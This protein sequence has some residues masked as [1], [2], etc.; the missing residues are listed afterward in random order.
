MHTVLGSGPRIQ[1]Q[2]LLQLDHAALHYLDVLRHLAHEDGAFE[3][4]HDEVGCALGVALGTEP[5]RPL[6][7]MERFCHGHA[8]FAED[9]SEALPET[10]VYIRQLR[11]EVAHGT[12]ADAIALALTVED[13]IQEAVDL[14]HGIRVTVCEG[15]RE[16]AVDEATHQPVDDGVAELFLA[17]EVVIEVA[18]AD[19][20]LA[21]HVVEG[22]AV[23]AL[24][25]N[26]APRRVEDL[27]PRRRTP[28]ALR[29]RQDRCLGVFHGRFVPN[30][31]YKCKHPYP[32]RW[33]IRYSIFSS[34]T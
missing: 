15:G 20:A 23:V 27:V 34:G 14:L 24:Q 3:G 33:L 16:R 28:G 30:S 31:G 11:G 25:V 18:L 32:G 21:Q 13:S 4:G 5:A 22:S 1:G 17:L 7:S 2:V 12:S 10:L 6:P 29:L 8:P 19:T 26:Q 9:V